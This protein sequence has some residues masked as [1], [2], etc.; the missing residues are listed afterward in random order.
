M[1]VKVHHGTFVFYRFGSKTPTEPQQSSG[2]RSTTKRFAKDRN[3]ANEREKYDLKSIS[4]FGR[5]HL[6]HSRTRPSERAGS[7]RNASTQSRSFDSEPR[8]PVLSLCGATDL[9]AVS[10]PRGSNSGSVTVHPFEREAN[11]RS[12]CSRQTVGRQGVQRKRAL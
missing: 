3:R 11:I 2:L 12:A 6:P 5:V 8:C 10:C 1:S 9:L 7:R 4:S